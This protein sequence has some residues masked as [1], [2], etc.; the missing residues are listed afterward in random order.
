MNIPTGLLG[1]VLDASGV[2]NFFDEHRYR[3]MIHRIYDS[4]VP[5]SSFKGSVLV[6][7][8]TPLHPRDGNMPLILE[9][10]QPQ[11]SIP[12]CIYLDFR[13]GLMLN[14]VG[15]SSPGAAYLFGLG[16]WQ[17]MTEP[18]WVSFM[19]VENTVE[20]RLEELRKFVKLFI[21]HLPE[22][23]GP[24][25][26]QINFSCPN[27]G[28]HGRGHDELIAEIKA[29]LEIAAEIA[30]PVMVKL[31]VTFPARFA[32]E[33]AT[34]E[35]CCG[36]CISNTVP[37]RTPGLGIDW[38]GLF[39]PNKLSPLQRHCFPWWKEPLIQPG[40]LSG[41]PLLPLVLAWIHEARQNGFVKHVNGGGGIM[42][43]RHVDL[44]KD[45]GADSI[46]FGSVATLRPYYLASIIRRAHQIF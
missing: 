18:M 46:F 24:V 23:R 34:H 35:C 36:I 39:G 32:K 44:M 43:P 33:V 45:V 28:L 16:K 2:R 25:G 21:K 17:S 3:Y 27:V 4:V 41:K 31:S 9:N 14:A 13:R 6:A 22:F 30:I 37:W 10:L 7:K 42:H 40:G 12:K 5:G 1:P 8:T 29:S 38:D 15:L 26:L 11:D 20:K 19:A